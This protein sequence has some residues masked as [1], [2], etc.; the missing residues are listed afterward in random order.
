MGWTRFLKVY[1][2]CSNRPREEGNRTRVAGAHIAQKLGGNEGRGPNPLILGAG[3]ASRIGVGK[4]DVGETKTQQRE[5]PTWT[6]S[7]AQRAQRSSNVYERGT[8]YFAYERL[9]RDSLGS[10]IGKRMKVMG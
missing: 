7:I 1:R 3:P 8:L 9:H 10:N 4:T 2:P 6:T 5:S